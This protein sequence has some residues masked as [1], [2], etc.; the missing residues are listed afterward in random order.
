MILKLGIQQALQNLCNWWPWV[1][2]D[3]FSG[4]VRLGR[5]YVW[6]GK[7]LQ[8]HLMRK[9][10]IKGLKLRNKWVNE[11]NL[12]PGGCP[13]PGAIYT[14]IW[15]TFSNLRSSLKPLGQSK[16]HFMWSQNR[17]SYD[18]ETWYA[19]YG[20]QALTSIYKWWPWVDLDLLYDMF[21]LGRLYVWMRK[22]VT[23]SFNGEL[24]QQMIK[25]TG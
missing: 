24:L 15:A 22:T 8:S 14:Y 4:K 2:H 18:L 3:H 12:T 13:C 17:N 21:K 10:Y 1:D 11:N 6:I 5:L 7:L 16:P 25:L 9:T 19:A 23:K 20:T